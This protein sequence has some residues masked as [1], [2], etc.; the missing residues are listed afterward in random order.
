MY[1]LSLSFLN[2]I[3]IFILLVPDF[4]EADKLSK[5]GSARWI[6]LNYASYFASFKRQAIRSHQALKKKK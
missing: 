2:E 1:N 4:A 5:Q 3:Y 6:W